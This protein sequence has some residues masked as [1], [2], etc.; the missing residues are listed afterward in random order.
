MQ[1]INWTEKFAS[2]ERKA[3]N[4]GMTLTFVNKVGVGFEIFAYGENGKMLDVCIKKT[5]E[6]VWEMINRLLSRA[7]NCGFAL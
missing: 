5:I 1:S 6:D 4:N 2:I 7:P 3:Q